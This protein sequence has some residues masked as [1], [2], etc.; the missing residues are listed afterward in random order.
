MSKGKILFQLSGSIA[1]FKACQVLS[2][3]VQSGYEVEVVATPGAL[4]FVGEATLEG[5][6]G[7]KVHTDTFAAGHQMQHIHLM[8]WADLVVL[9]P[10]T[11][12][13]INKLSTGIGDDLV[14][15]LFLAHDFKKPYLLVPAMNAAMWN[16]PSTRSSVAKLREWG[17]D[18]LDTASGN[19]A[20]GEVGDGRLPEPEIILA[21]IERRVRSAP[22][23]TLS[24]RRLKTLITS[25]GTQE[26]IDGVRAITNFSSG[27]TGAALASYF[28]SRGHDVTLLRARGSAEACGVSSREFTTFESLRESVASELSQSLFDVVIH[29]AAVGDYSIDQIEGEN[30]IINGKR[31]IESNGDLTLR[32]KR[33]PKIVDQLREYSRNPGIQVVA[34]KLTN[35]ASPDERYAAVQKL[36]AHAG[37]QFIVHNDLSEIG[38]AR[39]RAR[40]YANLEAGT[41]STAADVDSKL[42]L[43]RTLEI[44]LIERSP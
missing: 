28:A 9:C 19:L 39:H 27:R 14:S 15:T 23:K 32:L 34:F 12:N 11:A 43:A 21:E 5:L 35:G 30:G 25:G 4:R 16:H 42:E 1:C 38:P 2:R 24:N 7:R 18:V 20:C 8:R 22:S 17:L 33:N 6:S 41:L 36:A 31:K 29:A 10:A 40:V 13:T 37:A 3:L 26:P 44:L